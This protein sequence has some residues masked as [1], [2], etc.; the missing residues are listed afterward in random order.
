MQVLLVEDEQNI[1]DIIMRGLKSR[2]MAVER[3]SDGHAGFSRASSGEFDVV[4]LD[5]MLPGR[6][7]LSILRGLREAGNR[8]P[9]LLLSARNELDD[10]I[11]GLEMG[12]DD[13]LAKP[14]YVEELAT[15]L[16]V[17]LRRASGVRSHLLREG[18]LTLDCLARRAE[19]AGKHVDLTPREFAV[20]EYLMRSPGQTLSRSQILEKVWGYDFDPTTNI[21]D[22]CVR[23]LRSKLAE[24]SAVNEESCIESVRGQGYRFRSAAL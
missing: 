18:S 9:V 19:Q 21:V 24:A 17:L 5:I 3:C 7:G 8:T 4:V 1:A 22:V 14:F 23:R 6:D 12:A 10:R 11:D 2:G 20:L 13:Y 15:R 16:L